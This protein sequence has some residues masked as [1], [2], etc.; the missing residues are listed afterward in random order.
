MKLIKKDILK[1]ETFYL[2]LS[3]YLG[4]WNGDHNFFYHDSVHQKNL[5]EELAID[6]DNLEEANRHY[7]DLDEDDKAIVNDMLRAKELSFRANPTAPHYYVK[8][9]YIKKI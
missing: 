3:K 8:F 1:L 9:I 4:S 2:N 5:C 6:Q 7:N